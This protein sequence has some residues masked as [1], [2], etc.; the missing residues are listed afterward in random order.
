[1]IGDCLEKEIDSLNNGILEESGVQ[2]KR[3]L[4]IYPS[5]TTNK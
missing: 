5:T 2:R 4:L 3:G 1:M